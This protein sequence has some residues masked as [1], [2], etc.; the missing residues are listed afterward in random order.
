MSRALRD[1]LR[2]SFSFL[3][4]NERTAT[5]C[6]HELDARVLGFQFPQS[7][8]TNC[9]RWIQ[10]VVAAVNDLS[11]S[12]IGTNELQLPPWSNTLVARALFQFPQ[13]ERTNCNFILCAVRCCVATLSVSS[14]GT[15]ELQPLMSL[16][17]TSGPCAFSFLNRNERTATLLEQ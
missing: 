3:N 17:S 15:N 1:M 13:S 12:S 4:R 7:E 2:D 11:V 5:F 9:N 6:P 8:R 10:V 14:I 16:Q